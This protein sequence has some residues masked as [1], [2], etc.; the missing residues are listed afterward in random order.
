MTRFRLPLRRHP[1]GLMVAC[2]LLSLTAAWTPLPAP[3]RLSAPIMV[4]LVRHA[5]KV[6]GAG[7]DPPLT[8]AGAQRAQQLAAA[9]H[10]AGVSTVITSQWRRTKATAEPLATARQLTPLVIPIA[11]DSIE[12]HARAVAA[13]VRQAGG[14]VLVVGH[15][16]TVPAI[17]A[18]L[19]GPTLMEICST[20]Y[21]NLYVLQL[22]ALGAAHLVRGSYGAAAP[23]DSSCGAMVRP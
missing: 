22:D 18:A 21:A 10:D 6:L 2:A 19:G 11:G 4:I 8:P 9:L 1:R 5:E 16:D 12:P 23:R 15:S 7:N 14:V 3:R 20:D 13:A 17:I